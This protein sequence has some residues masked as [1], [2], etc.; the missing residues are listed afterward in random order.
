VVREEE[1]VEQLVV[2]GV[3]YNRNEAKIRV[4]GV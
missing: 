2:S 3:A 1:V 4:C